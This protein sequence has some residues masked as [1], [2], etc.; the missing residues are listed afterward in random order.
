MG[1]MIIA[2]DLADD[3]KVLV[4]TNGEDLVLSVEN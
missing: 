1:R 2:G 3:D 4:D